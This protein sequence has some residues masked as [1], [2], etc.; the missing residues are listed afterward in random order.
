MSVYLQ[1]LVA[2]EV[3]GPGEEN[4][5]NAEVYETTDGE[6]VLRIYMYCRI[7]LEYSSHT[8]PVRNDD[9]VSN[10]GATDA[11]NKKTQKSVLKNRVCLPLNKNPGLQAELMM[12]NSDYLPKKHRNTN[13]YLKLLYTP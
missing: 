7:V 5:Y 13:I 8:V 2:Q 6:N 3:W 11:E 1:L 10:S 12:A 4:R 9:S